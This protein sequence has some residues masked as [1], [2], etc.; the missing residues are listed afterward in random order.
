MQPSPNV[1]RLLLALTGLALFLLPTSLEPC[2][3]ALPWPPGGL[4]RPRPTGFDEPALAAG[5]A[6]AERRAKLRS[7]RVVF[8]H[9]HKAGGSTVC[10]LAAANGY[11]TNQTD[12]CLWRPME[13][14]TDAQRLAEFLDPAQKGVDFLALEPW[15]LPPLPSPGDAVFVAVVRHPLDRILSHWKWEG[16]WTVRGAR[17]LAVGPRRLGDLGYTATFSSKID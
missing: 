4:V 11:R 12:N 10:T 7:N 8:A 13:P 2:A 9:V 6:V 3:P 16:E 5:R 15:E 14:I 1:G 17:K